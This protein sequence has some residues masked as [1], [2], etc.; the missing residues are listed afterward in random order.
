MRLYHF[1]THIARRLKRRRRIIHNLPHNNDVPVTRTIHN[2]SIARRTQRSITC[3]TFL[4]IPTRPTKRRMPVTHTCRINR[5][6]KWQRCT[7]FITLTISC[8]QPTGRVIG[9]IT[10]KRPT[11]LAAPWATLNARPR[12]SSLKLTN[13][14]RHNRCRLIQTQTQVESEA[15]SFQRFRT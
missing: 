13:A 9:R 1:R 4:S 7:L 5:I 12:R 3:M 11:C 8:R 15:F 6:I 10:T 2:P 14:P